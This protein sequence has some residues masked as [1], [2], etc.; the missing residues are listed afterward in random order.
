MELADGFRRCRDVVIGG[1]ERSCLA[2]SVVLLEEASAMR[3]EDDRCN[4]VVV[5][6]LIFDLAAGGRMVELPFALGGLPDIDNGRDGLT[7]G[8]RLG[9]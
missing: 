1:R 8:N 9:D 4:P 6:L 3:F 5:G 7:V 2:G